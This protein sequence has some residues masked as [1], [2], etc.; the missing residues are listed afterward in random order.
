[1]IVSIAT[2]KAQTSFGQSDT[3]M[4]DFGVFKF[5]HH[6][7]FAIGRST[8]IGVL[9]NLLGIVVAVLVDLGAIVN[10]EALGADAGGADEL[11]LF[12][13][14]VVNGVGGERREKRLTG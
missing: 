7:H 9:P 5:L 6:P 2:V 12:G 3:K 4:I 11:D 1:M 10:I 8:V 13:F 14:L